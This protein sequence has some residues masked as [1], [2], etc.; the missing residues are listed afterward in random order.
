MRLVLALREA[1]D[2]RDHSNLQQ[3]DESKTLARS[4]LTAG[5]GSA[6]TD[7]LSQVAV[8]LLYKLSLSVSVQAALRRFLTMHNCIG[9]AAGLLALP[10]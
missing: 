2:H 4:A 5:L 6:W 9:R 8:Q 10:A 7:E 1:R 3:A